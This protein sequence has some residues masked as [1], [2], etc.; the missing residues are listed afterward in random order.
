VVLTF[1]KFKGTLISQVPTDYLVWLCGQDWVR[2]D[3][4]GAATDELY[5]REIEKERRAQKNIGQLNDPV[6]IQGTEAEPITIEGITLS[7]IESDKLRQARKTGELVITP[8]LPVSS[9]L[10]LAWKLDCQHCKRKHRVRE[11]TWEET[12]ATI[13]AAEGT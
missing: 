8:D 9:Q 6:L 3:L 5:R 13:K 11:V 1:G 12:E 7:P 2:Q 4:Q 10:P